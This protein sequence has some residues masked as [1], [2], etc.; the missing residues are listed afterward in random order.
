MD[1]RTIGE[2]VILGAD[3]DAP[4]VVEPRGGEALVEAAK[5]LARGGA[6]PEAVR[7]ARDQRGAGLRALPAGFP[8]DGVVSGGFLW[9]WNAGADAGAGG[10]SRDWWIR[11][12]VYLS[13]LY[14]WLWR[15]TD[16]PRARRYSSTPLTLTSGASLRARVRGISGSSVRAARVGG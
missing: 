16:A 9:I 5:E 10:C 11:A 13:A 1:A 4:I 8:R 2:F 15:P 6:L 14:L 12:D 7:L 3:A